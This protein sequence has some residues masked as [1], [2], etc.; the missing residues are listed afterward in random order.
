MLATFTGYDWGIVVV[1]ILIGSLPGFL[2]RKYIRGQG[3]FLVAGRT[4]SVF[5]ATAT[6]TA[7]EMGLI[8]VMYFAEQG[9]LKGFSAFVLSLIHI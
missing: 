5:L 2:L 4:L 7:T 1:Y 9:F 3:E 6:L 8:T